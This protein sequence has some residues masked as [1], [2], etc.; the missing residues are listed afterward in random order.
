[1]ETTNSKGNTTLKGII[2][3]KDIRNYFTSL[4]AKSSEKFDS[5]ILRAFSDQ[6]LRTPPSQL[7]EARKESQRRTIS[8]TPPISGPSISSRK[9]ER[10][11][12]LS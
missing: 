9:L 3:E 8:V 6:R 4:V 1:V 5:E 11:L 12:S 7:E 2:R 10:A